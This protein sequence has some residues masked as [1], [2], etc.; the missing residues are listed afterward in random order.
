MRKIV[1][2]IDLSAA[3]DKVIQTAARL[4]QSQSSQIWLVHVAGPNPDFV[5]YEAG[6]Q[7]VRDQIAAGLRDEHRHLQDIAD[8]VGSEGVTVTPLLVRGPT[9]ESIL[10]EAAKLQADVIVIG[11]HGHGLL[12]RALVG[13]VAQ[14]ILRGSSCPV[15]IVP[16]R[17]DHG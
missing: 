4:A 17:E 12:Y 16:V 1:V 8:T 14:G 10:N 15:L 3:T 5:G 9:V 13:S 6:P 11:S 7:V 2:G